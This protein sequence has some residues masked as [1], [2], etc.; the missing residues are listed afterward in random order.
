MLRVLVTGGKETRIGSQPAATYPATFA[1]IETDG[2][3][4][5]QRVISL[6]LYPVQYHAARQEVRAYQQLTVVRP[7]SVKHTVACIRMRAGTAPQS[8]Y[9]PTLARLL[10]NL[11]GS[12]CLPAARYSS[13]TRGRLRHLVARRTAP[14]TLQK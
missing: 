14:N 5:S 11:R 9:E 4:R 10:L 2:Y 1:N 3:I 6:A 7:F 13:G 8:L 12:A